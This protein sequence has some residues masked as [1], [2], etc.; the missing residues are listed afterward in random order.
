MICLSDGQKLRSR[1]FHRHGPNRAD[2]GWDIGCGVSHS[3]VGELSE[4]LLALALVKSWQLLLRPR[5]NGRCNPHCKPWVT[6][7]CGAP[8]VPKT[9]VPLHDAGRPREKDACES[10]GAVP[11]PY[12]YPG[13]HLGC[14][15]WEHLGGNVRQAVTGTWHCPCSSFVRTFAMPHRMS[16][17]WEGRLVG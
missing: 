9:L 10:D 17:L 5:L 14:L 7:M 15:P 8:L 16:E 2:E 6:R 1:S 12:T 3:S 13:A 4:V 11:P